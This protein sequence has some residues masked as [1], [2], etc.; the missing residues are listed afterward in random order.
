MLLFLCRFYAAVWGVVRNSSLSDHDVELQCEITGH[1]IIK[2]RFLVRCQYCYLL[3][4][5]GAALL[6]VLWLVTCDM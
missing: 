6:E 3:A 5:S 4:P 2:N 1:H